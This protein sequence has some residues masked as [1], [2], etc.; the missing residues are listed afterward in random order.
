MYGQ[1]RDRSKRL[2]WSLITSTLQRWLLHFFRGRDLLRG[3]RR[4]VPRHRG[5]KGSLYTRTRLNKVST[6]RTKAC[7][8]SAQCH[9]TMRAVYYH[10]VTSPH[11]SWQGLPI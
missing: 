4:E 7:I 9:A 10:K 2:S 3:L 5:R 1:R 8:I 6:M 11:A